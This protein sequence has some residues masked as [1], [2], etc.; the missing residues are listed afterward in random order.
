MGRAS[1][2]KRLKGRP[3]PISLL[4]PVYTYK[5]TMPLILT[6]LFWV[7]IAV[8]AGLGALVFG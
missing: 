1:R 3:A 5:G 7:F 8:V 6:F 2:R 4:S